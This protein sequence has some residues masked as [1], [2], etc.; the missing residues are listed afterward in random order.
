MAIRTKCL[1]QDTIIGIESIYTAVNGKQINIPDKVERLRELGRKELLFCPCGCGAN[2]ILVAGDKNLKEQHFRIKHSDEMEFDCK[3]TYEG[4]ES[5][6]S[7]II[8]KCWL[9]DKLKKSDLLCEVPANQIDD[10]DRKHE[11]TVY[12]S[13]NRV[14]I[15]YWRYR[16]NITDEKISILD[17]NATKVI[18]VV[19]EC[20][21][22]FTG[23]YPEFMMKIQKSQGFNLYLSINE[24]DALYDSATLFVSYFAQDIDGEWNELDIAE[25]YISHFDISNDGRLSYYGSHIDIMVQKALND[26]NAEQEVIK[27]QRIIEAQER[28]KRLEEERLE[29]ERL[30]AEREA[31]R[32]RRQKEWEERQE[33]IR[34][35]NEKRQEEI[36]K[37]AEE[38]KRQEELE[39]VEEEKKRQRFKAEIESLMDQQETQVRDPDGNRWIKCEICGKIATDDAFSSY[40]G[41]NHINLGT[42]KECDKKGLRKQVTPL[43]S[44]KEPKKTID[45]S[46]CPEC[47]RKL[48]ERNGRNGRF[49]GCTGFPNC[50]YSRSKW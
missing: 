40:G 33:Q 7:K 39:K 38:K 6:K 19:G 29:R 9:E 26:F 11:Y 14:G 43:A 48:I 24:D 50:R 10:T 17:T 15:G 13:D 42:C 16:A 32:L 8:L 2:L 21:E 46:I 41:P 30:A 36:K 49:I 1:Y 5:L 23:Q 25:D 18:Y 37:Q 3:V 47:G 34:I 44:V 22:G 4:E 35:E 27:Q 31:E 45:K 20:N 28:A 12:D